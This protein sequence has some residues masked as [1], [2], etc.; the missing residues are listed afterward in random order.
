MD[1]FKDILTSFAD[2][3]KSRIIN[4]FYGAFVVAWLA[5]NW[6][7]A[8]ALASDVPFRDK[9]HYV[10]TVLYPGPILPWIYCLVLPLL[11]A[12]SY[13]MLGPHVFRFLI[14]YWRKQQGKT[15]VKIKLDDGLELI[16]KEDAEALKQQVYDA[17]L[18]KRYVERRS[19]DQIAE[20]LQEMERLQQQISDLKKANSELHTPNNGHAGGIA[21][22]A[23]GLISLNQIAADLPER[24]LAALE[25]R[26]ISKEEAELLRIIGDFGPIKDQTQVTS[27]TNF[28]FKN[29]SGAYNML[30]TF[31]LVY[32]DPV[33]GYMITQAGKDVVQWVDLLNKAIG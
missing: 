23:D 10:D 17:L 27:A 33:N 18:Q 20:F 12:L 32:E 1:A 7:V 26:G 30:R 14:S 22:M 4:P 25:R 16:S 19:Q 15:R 31:R 11:S 28:K 6:R 3:F 8:L 13:I 9:V 24:L 5:L 21:V 29:L 2:W